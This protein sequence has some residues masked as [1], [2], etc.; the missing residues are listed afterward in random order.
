[1]DVTGGLAAALATIAN[2]SIGNY[3]DLAVWQAAMLLVSEVYQRF[4]VHTA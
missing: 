4:R 3:T 1:M 2:M